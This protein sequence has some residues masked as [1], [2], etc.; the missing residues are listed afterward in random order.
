MKL[1]GKKILALRNERCWSQEQLG[2]A[3]GLSARTIQRIEKDEGGSLESMKALASVFETNALSLHKNKKTTNVINESV[4]RLSTMAAFFIAIVLLGSWVIDILIPT[5]K[6][7][8][9]DKQYEIN[10]NFRY[11][12]YACVSFFV[13]VTI[14]CISAIQRFLNTPPGVSKMEKNHKD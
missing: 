3:A 5:L 11:L 9:F 10:G 2:A 1:D 12:D 14:F 4:I 7:A 8:N 13:G 6:G